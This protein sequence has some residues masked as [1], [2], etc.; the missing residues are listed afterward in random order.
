ME[1]QRLNVAIVGGG[2]GCKAIM[3]ILFAEKLSQLRMNLIGV[4]CTNAKA[5]GYRYA[6]ERGIYTT[7]DFRDL[8]GLEGLGMIIELTGRDEVAREIERT[9][10]EQVR[11]MDHVSARLFWDIFHIEEERLK[12]RKRAQEEIAIQKEGIAIYMKAVP[13]GMPW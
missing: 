13:T 11:L 7:E 4:A 2:P 1:A 5:V 6:Q 8:Y 9:R 3:D 10:P 12:E